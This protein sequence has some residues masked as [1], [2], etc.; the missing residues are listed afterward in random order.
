MKSF[1]L[2]LAVIATLHG[3]ETPPERHVGEIRNGYFITGNP[4]PE[5]WQITLHEPNQ[6]VLSPAARGG[7]ELTLECNSGGL[8]LAQLLRLEPGR[9]Y[10]LS[11]C[12][13]MSDIT[14]YIN[15]HLE[16]PGYPPITSRLDPLN[17]C[18]TRFSAT[19]RAPGPEAKLYFTFG[20][21]GQAL[22]V[23]EF[24]LTATPPEISNGGFEC[25]DAAL[26]AGWRSDTPQ[27]FSRTAAAV[28]GEYALQMSSG[29]G[30]LETTV[31]DPVPGKDFVLSGWVKAEPGGKP[32]IKISMLNVDGKEMTLPD[33]VFQLPGSGEWQHFERIFHL[34]EEAAMARLAV[35]GNAEKGRIW[36]DNL[37]LEEK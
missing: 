12:Y 28:K 29:T 27:L 4:L 30:F 24:R 7:R 13:R 32:Q 22:T 5:A 34:P 36:F 16:F 8:Q 1:F 3:Q 26:P 35:G 6:A 20:K 18:D 31:T 2:L 10:C 14:P 19:F 21:R 33:I 11:F 9:E 17:H 37:E 15:V 23:S 25:F